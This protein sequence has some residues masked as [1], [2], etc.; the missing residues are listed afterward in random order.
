MNGNVGLRIVT[1]LILIAA[2]AGVA[3]FAFQA[4]VAQGSPI[5]L[6]APS[7]ET[8]PL[9]YPYYGYGDGTGRTVSR[10]CLRN[11]TSVPTK[12]PEGVDKHPAQGLQSRLTRP[13]KSK[14]RVW[15]SLPE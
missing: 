5:T 11:G 15:M 10:P 4:G 8:A 7:G 1:A 3:F 12:S 2:V 6:Q 13:A 9:P 14:A